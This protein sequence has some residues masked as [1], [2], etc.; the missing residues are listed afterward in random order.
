ML[1]LKENC[2]LSLCKSPMMF[3]GLKYIP[4]RVGSCGNGQSFWMGFMCMLVRVR[5]DGSG[6][7]VNFYQGKKYIAYFYYQLWVCIWRPE[8]FSAIFN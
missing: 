5:F 4:I 7:V 1:Y 6:L 2:I 3:T 8:S